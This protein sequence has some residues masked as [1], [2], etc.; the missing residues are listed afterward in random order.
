M[1]K[2]IL[3]NTLRDIAIESE[4]LTTNERFSL[5]EIAKEVDNLVIQVDSIKQ[6][7]RE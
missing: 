2:S 3:G 6:E 1:K 7:I 4:G 5:Q